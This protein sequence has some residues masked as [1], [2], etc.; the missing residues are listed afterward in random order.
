[1]TDTHDWRSDPL[2]DADGTVRWRPAISV[3]RKTWAG[4]TADGQWVV[5]APGSHVL[6]AHSPAGVLSLLPLLERSMSEV[7][8]ELEVTSL[9]QHGLAFERVVGLALD[10]GAVFGQRLRSPG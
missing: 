7:A 9:T 8:A 1:M 3:Y 4:P 6:F 5:G 2:R 10:G